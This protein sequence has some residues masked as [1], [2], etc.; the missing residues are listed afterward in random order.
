MTTTHDPRRARRARRFRE[1]G[2]PGA[3][4]K[5]SCSARGQTLQ[6]YG[7]TSEGSLPEG[8][9]P[10]GRHSLRQQGRCVPGARAPEVAG[11]TSHHGRTLFR[12]VDRHGNQ[13]GPLG[14]R[15][16][17]R[18]VKRTAAAV[19]LEPKDF[20]GHTLRAGLATSAAKSGRRAHAIMKQTGH[21]SVAM[22][23]RYI[24]DAELFSDNAAAGLL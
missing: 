12:S 22:V 9:L 16:I 17:A 23:Q 15:D 8:S 1:G 24:R 20:A 3:V 10:K 2:G 4:V 5:S 19:G 21:P 14:D 13:A 18:I 6:C 7:A 11:A